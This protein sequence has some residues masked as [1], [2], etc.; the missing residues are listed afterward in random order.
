MVAASPIAEPHACGTQAMAL[1]CA[2]GRDLLAFGDAARGADVGL[3]DVHGAHR[4]D[5]AEAYFVNSFSPP[6]MAMS[7]ARV[8]ST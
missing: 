8:T 3:H 2:S 7:R 6:A 5:A 1:A 4:E